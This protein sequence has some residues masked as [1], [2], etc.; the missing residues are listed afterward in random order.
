MLVAENVVNVLCTAET[1]HL[2]SVLENSLVWG[3]R[4]PSQ[5]NSESLRKTVRPVRK[6]IAESACISDA[7]C[8]ICQP[9]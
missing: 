8:Q 7:T 6:R 1:I 5:L 9:G 4:Q 3:L 2:L